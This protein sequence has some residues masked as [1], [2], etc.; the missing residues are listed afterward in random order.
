MKL[1]SKHSENAVKLFEEGKKKKRKYKKMQKIKKEK[2][3][4]TE[5]KFN[6]NYIIQNREYMIKVIKLS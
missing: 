5:N 3:N 4:K 6:K 1:W 2:K